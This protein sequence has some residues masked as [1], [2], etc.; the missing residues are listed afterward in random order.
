MA[1]SRSIVPFREAHLPALSALLRATP[2]FTAEEAEVGIEVLQEALTDEG[3]L[4]LV[5]EADGEAVG[6]ACFGLTP[7][8]KAAF[9]LYW[10]AVSPAHKRHGLGRALADA[11][12][13]D[14]A[15]RGGR[16]LRVETEGGDAYA[17]TRA[18]Y[19]RLEFEV[20]G[21]IRAFYDV[22]RDLVVYVKYL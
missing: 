21:R 2:E 10:I 4:V 5:A 20:A 22:G 11:T 17:A 1:D 14:V 15:A 3:Y 19:E 8:T 7:M 9:D 12:L 13:A 6:Y 16:V 18:F